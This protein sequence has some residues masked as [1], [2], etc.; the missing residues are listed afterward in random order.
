MM[1]SPAGGKNQSQQVQVDVLVLRCPID[2]PAE[3]IRAERFPY[4]LRFARGRRGRF[5]AFIF[6]AEDKAATFLSSG[7]RRRSGGTL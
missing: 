1:P 2:I 7:A 3:K 5:P 6:C 4:R